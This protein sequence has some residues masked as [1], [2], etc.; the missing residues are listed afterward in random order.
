MLRVVV[1]E[2]F[3]RDMADL[4]ADDLRHTVRLLETHGPVPSGARPGHCPSAPHQPAARRAGA[5]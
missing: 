1:R 4:L 2:N 3:S 5:T